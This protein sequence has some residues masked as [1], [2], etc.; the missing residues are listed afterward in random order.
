M[1]TREEVPLNDRWNV[2]A[3]YPNQIAWEQAFKTFVP[4]LQQTPHWPALQ[5]YQGSFEKG[6]E[7]V[8]KALDLMMDIDRELSKLYTYA[9]L[10]HDED[11]TNPEFKKSYEQ[12]LTL[13]HAFAQETAWFQPELM[14][15]SDALLSQYLAS[16]LL[17]DYHFYLEK[18]IRMKKH[19]LSPDNEKLMAFAGQA[20]QTSYKAFS[21]IN[22]ADFKF[23]AV[24]DSQE[25]SKPLSHAT[26]GIYIRDQD[27]LLREHAFKQYH[28]QY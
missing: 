15:L 6:P 23:E 26:Y 11:I 1:K 18:M 13:A 21:A 14:A 17:A 20:L 5:A 28:R 25:E 22:D 12:I 4:H 8:K 24:L 2:E 19:T 9:H 3:L 27:R 16:P 10:R 7:Q